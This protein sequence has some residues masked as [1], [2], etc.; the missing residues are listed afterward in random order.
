MA[1]PNRYQG[2]QTL[3]RNDLDERKTNGAK[4]GLSENNTDE[5][6]VAGVRVGASD[7]SK[8]ASA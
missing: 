4:Q 8:G 1:A 5:H 7:A 6:V 2:H 3:L